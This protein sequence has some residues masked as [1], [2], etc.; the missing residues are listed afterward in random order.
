MPKYN[1]G[2]VLA[3]DT[4]T[5]GRFHY[6]VTNTPE[7]QSEGVGRERYSVLELTLR[8][9]MINEERDAGVWRMRCPTNPISEALENNLNYQKV[10]TVELGNEVNWETVV[11]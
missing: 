2:D 4:E 8:P 10:D 9:S 11:R 6:L 7:T 5:D 3:V 1:T